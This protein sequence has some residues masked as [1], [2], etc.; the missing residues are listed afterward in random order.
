MTATLIID[1]M[2]FRNFRIEIEDEALAQLQGKLTARGEVDAGFSI[3][4]VGPVGDVARDATGVAV[5]SIERRH[6]WAIELCG[7]V[8]GAGDPNRL[9]VSGIPI[10]VRFLPKPWER[11]VR[12]LLVGGRLHVE[13][14][15]SEAAQ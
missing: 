12:V 8:G 7:L 11:G 9:T 6:P 5:W 2:P 1:Q 3:H 4:R 14:L 13:S 15:P 10:M